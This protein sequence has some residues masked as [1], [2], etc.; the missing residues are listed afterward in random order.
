M[1]E[2]RNITY[3]P[4]TKDCMMCG[5]KFVY[6]RTTSQ[7]C[8]NACKCKA[9]QT[10]QLNEKSIIRVNNNVSRNK[11]KNRA[12]EIINGPNTMI[13]NLKKTITD[14][15]QYIDHL[16]RQFDQFCG[17]VTNEFS[18]TKNYYESVIDDNKKMTLDS[19]AAILNCHRERVR[20]II[21]KAERRLRYYYFKT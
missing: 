19:I 15:K 21:G 9:Y 8:S 14:Q 13:G 10:R 5:A 3:P 16:H 17:K 18:K 7:Y 20:N 2:V 6:Q 11:Q 12:D 1:E 4:K